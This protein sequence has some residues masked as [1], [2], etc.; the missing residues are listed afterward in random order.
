MTGRFRGKAQIA[1]LFTSFATVFVILDQMF[2][3]ANY[4][5]LIHN[6]EPNSVS[7]AY[8]VRIF[9][10]HHI[11]INILKSFSFFSGGT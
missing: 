7:D 1:I 2:W 4:T 9:H 10:A 5:T 6:K 3:N 11:K 8:K